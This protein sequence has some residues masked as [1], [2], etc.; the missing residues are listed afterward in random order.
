MKLHQMHAGYSPVEDR[1]R[2]K[3]STVEG[4]E[5]VFWLT[6]RVIAVMFG[7]SEKA[8]VAR[9]STKSTAAANPAGAAKAIVEFEREAAVA[10]GDFTTPYVKE[11]HAKPLG[12]KPVLAKRVD[13]APMPERPDVFRISILLINDMTVAFSAPASFIHRLRHLIGQA[14]RGANWGLD[15]ETEGTSPEASA[16]ERPRPN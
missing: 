4:Q 14:L 7:L 10:T 12:E 8:L 2:L 6:R 11:E 13:I 5:F 16:A 3:I 15:L 1:L 9:A